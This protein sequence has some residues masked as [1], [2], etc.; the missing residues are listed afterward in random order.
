MR[1]RKYCFTL[2]VIIIVS[3]GVVWYLEVAKESKDVFDGTL[4]K[5]LQ[6]MT[7]IRSKGKLL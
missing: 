3:I 5:G 1:I 2:V 6:Y 7:K 4:V